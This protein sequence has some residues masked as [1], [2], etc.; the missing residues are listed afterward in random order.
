MSIEQ[1]VVPVERSGGFDGC[2]DGGIRIVQDDSREGFDFVRR[3]RS[4]LGALESESEDSDVLGLRLTDGDLFDFQLSE[5]CIVE[6]SDCAVA[7]DIDG[8]GDG[9]GDLD[10]DGVFEACA[11]R[12][13]QTGGDA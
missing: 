1:L 5:F 6:L 4:V 11:A 12:V 2:G 9:I 7:Q 13:C 10:V 3:V 8:C